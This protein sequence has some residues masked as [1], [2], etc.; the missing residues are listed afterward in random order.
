VGQ[1]MKSEFMENLYF[2]ALMALVAY[3][4]FWVL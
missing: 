2:V 4:G 3:V 1:V